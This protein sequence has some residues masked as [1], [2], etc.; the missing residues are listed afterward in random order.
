MP[1]KWPETVGWS[2]GF[3]R[4]KVYSIGQLS[5]D[6]ERYGIILFLIVGA[7]DVHKCT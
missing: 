7:T 2:A 3:V 1:T 6:F 5:I 4:F